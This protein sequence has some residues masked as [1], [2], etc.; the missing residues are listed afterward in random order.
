MSDI[1]EQAME[2]YARMERMR[3]L[4]MQTSDHDAVREYQRLAAKP[5]PS[6]DVL[7]QYHLYM[8]GKISAAY[9]SVDDHITKLYLLARDTRSELNNG[10]SELRSMLSQGEKLEAMLAERA[11][12]IRERS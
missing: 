11:K 4:S 7:E 10:L 5:V 12:E 2:F 9:E 8:N 3:E 6:V 1:G